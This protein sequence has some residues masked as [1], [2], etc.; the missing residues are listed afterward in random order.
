MVET[1][2]QDVCSQG[3]ICSGAGAGYGKGA[4]FIITGFLSSPSTDH[5]APRKKPSNQRRDRMENG[6]TWHHR[7][8][9]RDWPVMLPEGK[10]KRVY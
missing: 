9:G 2:V 3:E 10:Q 6:Q 5:G 4:P 8:F 7:F 1:T